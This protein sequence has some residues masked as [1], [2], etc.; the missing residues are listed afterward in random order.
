MIDS[1]ACVDKYL[2]FGLY[3]LIDRS[4]SF[5]FSKTEGWRSCFSDQRVQ[6]LALFARSWS[7]L[8]RFLRSSAVC[9]Q[10]WYWRIQCCW[11][12]QI[13]SSVLVSNKYNLVSNFD[14][15]EVFDQEL[16][17]K[18]NFYYL[19]NGVNL[20]KM[21]ESARE[22]FDFLA[23]QHERNGDSEEELKVSQNFQCF[24]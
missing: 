17:V 8:C 21:T 12:W 5:Y 15:S 14:I 23:T 3:A 24:I 7:L 22:H 18:E 11:C 4:D 6:E 16:S 9:Y 2:T 1:S 13:V 10:F 20:K 19:G